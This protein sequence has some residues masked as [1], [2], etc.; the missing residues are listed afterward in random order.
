MATLSSNALSLADHAKRVDPEGK[1]PAIVELLAQT[2]E[3]LTDMQFGFRKNKS[4]SS[5]LIELTNNVLKAFNDG[6][7]V[8]GV[9]LD[10]S[11]AFDTLDF[12]V[13]KRK[14]HNLNFNELAVNWIINF[15]TNRKQL[16]IINE[17]YSE[18]LYLKCG[19]PQGSVLGPTL[20]LIYINDLTQITTLFSPILYA[21]DTNLFLESA[22]LNELVPEINNELCLI[23]NWCKQ[24]K[25]TINVEKTNFVILKN[26]QNKFKFETDSIKMFGKTLTQKDTIKFLGVHLDCHL[27]WKTHINNLLTQLRPSTGLLYKRGSNRP[28]VRD[29]SHP[30]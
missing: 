26:F 25:L 18:P 6:K 19:V 8:L 20:F 14:L 2:N 22:N 28:T 12:K 5:A 1:I 30:R 15:L 10:F 17:T 9:F 24:N 13:L 29:Q 21:D 27:N 23:Q 7:C 11:K 3:I 4:T 16:T